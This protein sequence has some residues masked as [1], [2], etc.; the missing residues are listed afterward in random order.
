M[1]MHRSPGI[2]A[3]ISGLF[4]ASLVAI[5]TMY[6]GGQ[7][8]DWD[9]THD[10]PVWLGLFVYFAYGGLMAAIVS[11]GA[12]LVWATLCWKN[13]SIGWWFPPVIGSILIGGFMGLS[14]N[15]AYFIFSAIT[16]FSLDLPSG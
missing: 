6:V 4:G 16:G 7:F 14:G 11:V 9:I 8:F 12:L 2:I 1:T 5:F 10:Q 15:L 3:V 13:S